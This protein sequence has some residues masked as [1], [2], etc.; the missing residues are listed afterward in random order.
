MKECHIHY[1][2]GLVKVSYLSSTYVLLGLPLSC[3]RGPVHQ[4]FKEGAM[5]TGQ[6]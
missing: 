5:G 2:F 6:F 1:R 3:L 4:G